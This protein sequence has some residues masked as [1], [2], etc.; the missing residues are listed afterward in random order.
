MNKYIE[1]YQQ[2]YDEYYCFTDDEP[3]RYLSLKYTKPN[4]QHRELSYTYSVFIHIIFLHVNLV[5]ACIYGV[6]NS[7]SCLN[8]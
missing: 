6:I 5:G 3:Y 2:N 4:T 8:G 7:P 1:F